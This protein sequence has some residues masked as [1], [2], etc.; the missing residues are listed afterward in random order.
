MDTKLKLKPD[1]SRN[2]NPQEVNLFVD[3]VLYR[4]TAEDRMRFAAEYNKLVGLD[5]VRVES[6]G[7]DKASAL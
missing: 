7:H 3:H 1:H 4:W 5:V 2:L 6:I